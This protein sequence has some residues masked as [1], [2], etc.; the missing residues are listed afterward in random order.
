LA[1]VTETEVERPKYGQKRW[2][3]GKSK[4]HTIKTQI[5]ICAKTK[6]IIAIFV[7]RG[8]VHDFTMWKHSI[9]VKVVKH[10]K[11]QAD[12]GY[13]GIQ[14]LHKNSET[15]KK[16]TKTK[17][18]TKEEKANNR[19]IGSERIG[20]EHKNRRLK[21]FRILAG[22]YRNRRRRFGLRMSLFCG[23]H[24]FELINS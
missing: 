6:V 2:Y 20:I 1:D 21:R 17:P 9:G 18:L 22:R 3:S 14:K 13:Q 23:L 4:C 10:I 5:V 19:R 24:N 7:C 16:K 11:I 8:S 15:P 12:S